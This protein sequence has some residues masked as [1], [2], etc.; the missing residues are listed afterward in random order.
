MRLEDHMNFA[1]AALPCCSQRGAN[2]R[3]MM[4]VIINHCHSARLP[5]NL[6]TAI[7]TA[8][9]FEGLLDMRHGNI[10]PDSHG[11]SSRRV[12][13][14]VEAGHVQMKFTEIT[15]AISNSEKRSPGRSRPGRAAGEGT[16]PYVSRGWTGRT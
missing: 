13:H 6:K 12:Q 9:I 15:P 1:I 16:R 11:N 4:P 14:I 3:G 10:Q 2:F 7:Y 8:K 5:A